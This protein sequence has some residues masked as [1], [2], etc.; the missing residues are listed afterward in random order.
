MEEGITT[1]GLKFN[2]I[3]GIKEYQLKGV[4]GIEWAAGYWGLATFSTTN[5][6]FICEFPLMNDDYYYVHGAVSD[7]YVKKYEPLGLVDLKDGLYV[8]DKEQTVCD[9]LR[10]DRHEFH[11]YEVMVS[12]DEGLVDRDKLNHMLRYYG[13]EEKFNQVMQD[14]LQAE[15]EDF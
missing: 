4:L 9:M 6:I 1:L 2:G 11:L 15:D 8:T 7:M 5:P 12:V 3:D 14:A 13:L 10:Y